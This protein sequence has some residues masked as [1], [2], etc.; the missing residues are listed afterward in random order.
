[1]NHPGQ[2]RPGIRE[3]HLLRK[4]ANPLFGD[5]PVSKEDLARARLA[6]GMEQDDFMVIFQTLVRQAVELEPNTPTETVLELKEQLDRCYQQACALPGD[7]QQVKQAIRK[8]Q[9]VIMQAMQRGAGNDAFAQQQLQ[10]EEIARQAHF[11]LQELPLVAALTHA[12]SPIAAT[13]LIP[14]LLSEADDSLQRSL[15]IFDETQL[16]SI[17]HEARAFLQQHDPDSEFED[18]WRRLELIESHYRALQP[19]SVASQDGL[20]EMP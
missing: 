11:E 5:A 9:G 1:M 17:C 2:H 8:L 19:G 18:A 4:Q 3:Q 12:D 14:S 13:E 15:V 16:A 6:D 20:Q 7:M 10:E